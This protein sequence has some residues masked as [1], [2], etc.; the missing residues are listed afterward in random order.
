VVQNKKKNQGMQNAKDIGVLVKILK[1]Q[2]VHLHPSHTHST[3]TGSSGSYFGWVRQMSSFNM[4]YFREF[5][6]GVRQHG[7]TIVF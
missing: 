6:N 5:T 2:G 4:W 3:A 7:T 1:F